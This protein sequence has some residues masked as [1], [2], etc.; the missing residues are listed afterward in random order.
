MNIAKSF[1]E[2]HIFTQK[3][4]TPS[5][6]GGSADDFTPYSNKILTGGVPLSNLLCKNTSSLK[7]LSH[8]GIPAGLVTTSFPTMKG[9][10]PTQKYNELKLMSYDTELTNKLFS[11]I[12]HK[13]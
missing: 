13:T 7:S 6:G 3:E 11:K 1:M 5:T 12:Q 8:L 10:N 2:S 4:N 9:G